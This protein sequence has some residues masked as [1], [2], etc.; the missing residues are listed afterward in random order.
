MLFGVFFGLFSGVVGTLVALAYFLPQQV[1]TDTRVPLR[2]GRTVTVN[3]R[4]EWTDVRFGA[5]ERAETVF[6][7][8]AA[9]KGGLVAGAYVASEAVGIGVVLTSDGWVL[10]HVDAL[11]VQDPN[12]LIAV[13]DGKSYPVRAVAR[14]GYSGAAFLKLDGVNFPVTSFGDDT[15][16][17]SGDSLFVFDASHGIRRV[18]VIGRAD[19]PSHEAGDFVQSSER[20]QQ[21]LRVEPVSGLL[22]GAAVIDRTG[23][24]VGI[25]SR[26]ENGDAWVVPL[27]S[28]FNQISAILRGNA[29]SRPFLGVNYIDLSRLA[30]TSV[31]GSGR[32]GAQLTATPDGR[33]P[34]VLRR[35]PAEI[36][37]LR[38]GDIISAINDDE[39]SA[40]RPFAD[41]LAQY[42]PGSKVIIKYRRGTL[43]ATAEVNLGTAPTN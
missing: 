26:R 16:I 14:D 33:K 22:P 20:I 30:V 32:R 15:Q 38:A 11:A 28:F 21:V 13:V 18:E 8:P 34:A 27:G 24:M 35:S 9:D 12:R 29:V 10:T 3:D 40:K 5:A 42:D 17:S 19:W 31:D 41:M 1:V 7:P 2:F 43:E 4:P 25:Y 36:A 37:G 6:F 39:I 23:Q